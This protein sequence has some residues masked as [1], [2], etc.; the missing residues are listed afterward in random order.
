MSKARITV[1][2]EVDGIEKT[3]SHFGANPETILEPRERTELEKLAGEH[4]DRP[5]PLEHIVYNLAAS[6]IHEFCKDQE[7]T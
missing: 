5:C 3:I 4:P 6:L 7:K 1:T 2:L